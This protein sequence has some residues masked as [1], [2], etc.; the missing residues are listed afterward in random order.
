MDAAALVAELRSPATG[1]ARR[2]ACCKQLSKLGVPDGADAVAAVVDVLRNCDD[3]TLQQQSCLTLSQLTAKSVKNQVVAGGVGAIA[4]IVAVMRANPCD[5]DTLRMGCVALA[6]VCCGNIANQ[7]KAGEAVISVTEALLV[8]PTNALLQQHG[9]LTLGLIIKQ[10]QRNKVT[11]GVAGAVAA[12]LAAMRACGGAAEVQHPCCLVLSILVRDVQQNRTSAIQAGAVAAVVDAL[13]AH[14]EDAEVQSLGCCALGGLIRDDDG[15]NP[16][17]PDG[18][19]LAAKAARLAVAALIAHRADAEVQAW[20]GYAIWA[21]SRTAYLGVHINTD[22]IHALLVALRTHRTNSEVQRYCCDAL[23]ITISRNADNIVAATKAGAFEAVK[24]AMQS[25]PAAAAVQAAG[26]NAVCALAD[27]GQQAK[28]G[29]I[30]AVDDVCAAMRAHAADALVQRNGCVAIAC[31][32][33]KHR[34]NL[35]AACAAGAIEAVVAAADTSIEHL[36][37]GSA[38]DTACDALK[39]IVW[40]GDAQEDAALRAGALEVLSVD[41]WRATGAPHEADRVHVIARLELAARRHDAGVCTHHATCKRCAGMR[42][43]GT[44]C[45]LAGCCARMRDAR[46][47]LLRCGRCGVACYCGVAH[48]RDDWVRHKAECRRPSRDD[49]EGEDDD[50]DDGAAE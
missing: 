15:C 20:A 1:A 48:Q 40:G 32:V 33:C 21:L 3:T 10:H 37:S 13:I 9:C 45:A 22:G 26:C 44:M 39:E 25:H 14:P 47:K 46:K 28:A 43:A 6:N 23:G 35:Q 18:K 24:A 42:A 38:Y 7:D 2:I 11:A 31:L 36:E 5:P 16:P 50:D 8:Y 4:A 30:G 29:N 49:D 41:C 17:I 12:V 27:G 34:E 19:R